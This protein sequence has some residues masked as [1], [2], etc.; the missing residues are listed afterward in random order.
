VRRAERRRDSSAHRMGSDSGVELPAARPKT[1]RAVAT[2]DTDRGSQAQG[3]NPGAASDATRPASAT[4]QRFVDKANS[5]GGAAPRQGP[6]TVRHTDRALS[7]I[8]PGHMQVCFGRFIAS[9]LSNAAPTAVFAVQIVGGALLFAVP[10]PALT[11]EH[12]SAAFAAVGAVLFVAT[13]TFFLSTALSDPG[14]LPRCNTP[15]PEADGAMSFQS[16]PPRKQNFVAHG[17]IVAREYCDTCRIFRPPLAVHC[18]LCQNCVR[19]YDHHCPWVG[20]CIGARNYRYFVGFLVSASITLVYSLALSILHI[21]QVASESETGRDTVVGSVGSIVL[22]ILTIM[23]LIFV[24]ALLTFHVQLLLSNQTAFE[25]LKS[26]RELLKPTGTG[27]RPF[28]DLM[29]GPRGVSY[30][31]AWVRTAR[32]GAEGVAPPS[33][34]VYAL[35]NRGEAQQVST[36][37]FDPTRFFMCSPSIPHGPPAPSVTTRETFRSF[38]SDGRNGDLHTSS[39]APHSDS[40]DSYA[41]AM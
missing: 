1:D 34:L 16:R 23:L 8:W 33:K 3:P 5:G 17:R 32:H 19:R 22:V 9:G 7:K 6:N 25:Q 41:T 40:V 4:R 21:K 28:L 2:A 30:A 39:R 35:D 10:V 20:N 13:M 26:N 11:K 24:V 36:S 29:F 38:D 12:N 15:P 18:P 27:I 37:G 31:Q 14:L